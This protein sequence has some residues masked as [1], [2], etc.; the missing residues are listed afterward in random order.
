MTVPPPGNWRDSGTAGPAAR[1]P[2]WDPLLM[3]L[4]A[5]VLVTTWRV[6]DLVPILGTLQFPML[7]AAAAYA[8]Y[9]LER[10]RRRMLSGI[11]HPVTTL[12]VVLLIL[13]VASV[14]GGVYPGL[15]FRFI[16]KD[17][18]KT[19]GMMLLI[20][21]S[22]RTV[23]DVERF[24]WVQVLGAVLY[25]LVVLTSVSVG[26]N[27]RLGDLWYYDA[28]DLGMLL[29]ATLP[30]MIYAIRPGVRTL[31]RL[32]GL[33][34]MGVA[35]LTV[36]KTGSRGG[37]LAL[38]GSGAY[39]LFGFQAIPKRVRVLSVAALVVLFMAI[40]NDHYWS[41][42][43]TL[44]HPTQDYNWSGKAEEG[45]ME[46]W[47]RGMGYMLG[48]PFV[49]VGANAFPVAE[50]TLSPYAARQAI[51]IGFKWS[52]AH[53]SFVQIGAELG[54]GGLLCFLALLYS[55]FRALRR[56]DRLGRRLPGSAPPA[57]L[58]QALIATLLAYCIGGFF[59]SQ[60]Y[61][62]LLYAV[63]GMIVGLVKVARAWARTATAGPFATGGRA[64]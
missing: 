64:A 43:G 61:S 17:H 12:A 11:K 33:A 9:F 20:A 18:I 6:Q 42:M 62:P 52:A 5:T 59:L 37:F 49:G 41:M 25:A 7:A 63:L 19:L 21:A 50:G 58:A 15:S 10:D 56:V 32:L 30:L 53:N 2:G 36:V 3:C 40:A 45:R 16:F 28:N 27:G 4:A 22:I 38:L 51:G 24:A 44:L 39:L 57:A 26:T 1:A 48:S 35:T 23:T 55:A 8:T 29:A 54:V 47:K 14:P 13:M 46:I 60:A 34:G 31:H